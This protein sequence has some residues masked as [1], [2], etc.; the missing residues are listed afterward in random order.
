MIFIK[1]LI[2]GKNKV[3]ACIL[4]FF[5]LL[6][7]FIVY[8]RIFS[9]KT[10]IASVNP[11]N[12]TN[13]PIVDLYVD[14]KWGGA[15]HANSGGGSSVCCVSIPEKW[16]KNFLVH[17]KWKKTEDNKWYTATAKV[18]SYT[19]PAGLQILFVAN[20]EI[21]VFVN[22]YWPCSSKHPMPKDEKLCGVKKK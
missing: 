3:A 9:E 18:P 19:E 10:V 21:K 4:L 17:V 13:V 6:F 12:F 22:D 14:E 16:H 8:Q 7:G 15:V 2:Y 1:R 20:D 5:I 11:Y